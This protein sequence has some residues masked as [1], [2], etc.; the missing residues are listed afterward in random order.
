MYKE[1]DEHHLFVFRRDGR[2]DGEF[3]D[4]RLAEGRYLSTVEKYL[5][6]ESRQVKDRTSGERL[7]YVCKQTIP[8]WQDGVVLSSNVRWSF[9]STD[10]D[11]SNPTREAITTKRMV[12]G[13][14]AILVPGVYTPD[15]YGPKGENY[16]VALQRKNR[17]EHE[18]AFGQV[19]TVFQDSGFIN[20][21]CCIWTEW[22]D[23]DP[24]FHLVLSKRVKPSKRSSNLEGEILEGETI[25]LPF[26]R[27]ESVGTMEVRLDRQTNAPIVYTPD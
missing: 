2:S 12:R 15:A 18:I 17:T 20:G 16:F 10:A 25:A 24:V 14:A 1:S 5:V 4:E 21:R 26:I 3:R 22:P 27:K 19:R 8:V 11:G 7:R 9:L 23:D 6:A 13:V